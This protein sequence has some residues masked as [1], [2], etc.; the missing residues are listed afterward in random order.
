MSRS[1]SQRSE[2]GRGVTGRRAAVDTAVNAKSFGGNQAADAARLSLGISRARQS[3][4]RL[5]GARLSN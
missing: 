1:L 2:N 3:S 4:K 5:F